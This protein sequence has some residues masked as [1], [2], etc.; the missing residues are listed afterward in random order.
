MLGRTEMKIIF[1]EIRF[2]TDKAL[3]IKKRSSGRDSLPER[4][5]TKN[6]LLETQIRKTDV[7]VVAMIVDDNVQKCN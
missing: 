3:A 5:S 7:E 2:R 1:G 6:Y 4:P